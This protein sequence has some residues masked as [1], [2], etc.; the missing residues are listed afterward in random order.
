M[1]KALVETTNKRSTLKRT[2]TTKS[3][4]TFQLVFQ[5]GNENAPIFSINRNEDSQQQFL[6]I[7]SSKLNQSTSASINNNLTSQQ[8]SMSVNLDAEYKPARIETR[9]RKSFMAPLSGN[10]SNQIMAIQSKSEEKDPKQQDNSTLVENAASNLKSAFE[11]NLTLFLQRLEKINEQYAD[12]KADLKAEYQYQLE[13]LKRK[14]QRDIESA[15]KGVFDIWRLNKQMKKKV[16]KQ[17][18]YCT[19]FILIRFFSVSLQ[20]STTCKT[21]LAPLGSVTNDFNHTHLFERI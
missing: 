8:Q 19:E 15:K 5:R 13:D 21:A 3:R 7:N 18:F 1:D 10:I 12:D 14:Y 11:K 9:A 6:S 4:D 2:F 20:I 17:I 16:L